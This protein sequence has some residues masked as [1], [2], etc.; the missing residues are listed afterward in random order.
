MFLG[1]APNTTALCCARFHPLNRP[2]V[3][4][5]LADCTIMIIFTANYLLTIVMVKYIKQAHCASR[6][7][8][9]PPLNRSHQ[10]NKRGIFHNKTLHIV[11]RLQRI[12]LGRH[13]STRCNLSDFLFPTKLSYDKGLC[14]FIPY[15]GN[16][17]H[18]QKNTVLLNLLRFQAEI[19]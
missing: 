8:L 17:R 18:Q 7:K 5:E 10:K 9:F 1:V 15:I 19:S 11:A 4:N 16:R 12:V 3:A 6:I 14:A 13:E 2:T